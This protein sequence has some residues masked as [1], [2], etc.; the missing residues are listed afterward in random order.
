MV[1]SVEENDRAAIEA[2]GISIIEFKR[3]FY[4]KSKAATEVLESPME[5]T[6][7]ITKAWNIFKKRLC[8]A[9]D[10]L[11]LVFE[12][13]KENYCLPTSFRYKVVKF[14]SR[15]TG[16]DIYKLWKMT[17]HAWLARSCC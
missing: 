3:I 7:R 13:V 2:T 5:Y 4:R 12:A 14:L 1:I 8:E 11:K 9:A 6:Q 10:S 16:I 15:C 17:R